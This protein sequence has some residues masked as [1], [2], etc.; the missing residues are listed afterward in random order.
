MDLHAS[1]HAFPYDLWLLNEA[2]EKLDEMIDTLQEATG[3][4]AKRPRTYREKARHDYLLLSKQR[5]PR[6]QQIRRAIKKQLQ[7]VKRNLSLVDQLLIVSEQ[8]HC[9]LNTRQ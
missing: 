1:R 6:K 8:E 9:P 2:R 4:Q 5:S 3:K 7:Y